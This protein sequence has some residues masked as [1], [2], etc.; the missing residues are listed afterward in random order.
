MEMSGR[1]LYQI[2]NK[3]KTRK[4]RRMLLGWY[5]RNK[6][7]LP[8][9]SNPTPYRVWIAEIML[10]QTRVQAALPFYQR[11]LG[12]FPNVEALAAASQEE[13]LAAW[14]GLGYYA[15]AQNLRRAAE[16]I[17]REFGG[18]LPQSLET[19]QR[20]PGIGR[21]TAGAI[22]SIAFNQPRPVVDGNVRRLI[23]R[24]H[25]TM[26]RAP[27][28]FLWEQAADLV[29]ARRASDFNQ[30][31]MEL[32]AL[33]CLPAK[34]QCSSC[35]VRNLCVACARGMENRRPAVRSAKASKA[36]ELVVL[37]VEHACRILVTSRK[38]VGF[39]P[40][41]WCLPT[42]ALEGDRAPAR[43]AELLARET[44]GRQVT[45]R[46]AGQVRHSITWR[47]LIAHVFAADPCEMPVLGDVRY[48]WL[49]LPEA[50]RVLTS[51]LYG[52]AISESFRRD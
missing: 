24:L 39:I 14:A 20:L 10:Q 13:V 22:C 7:E 46:A 6:R 45:V 44:L 36:L 40:G 33:V 9:R 1:P 42:R 48:R 26:R 3:E 18:K 43:A 47:R 28:E 19:L 37:V 17:V 41:K 32:G 23:G 51:S 31:L 12:R 15:R 27:E 50:K 11:F 4:F 52:K 2:W 29:P 30:A 8:W 49:K 34:P 5:H 21:Y 16:Q 38:S 35:P 25:G